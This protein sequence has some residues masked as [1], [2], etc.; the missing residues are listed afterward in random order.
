ML[1][2]S[3]NWWLL[4]ICLSWLCTSSLKDRT[5]Q[6]LAKLTYVSIT[7][8]H[9]IWRI[10][11]FLLQSRFSQNALISSML[12]AA[13]DILFPVQLAWNQ[14]CLRA[15]PLKPWPRTRVRIWVDLSTCWV[16]LSIPPGYHVKISLFVGQGQSYMSYMIKCLVTWPFGMLDS[17]HTVYAIYR[18]DGSALV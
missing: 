10:Q 18:S 15:S 4:Q 16:D 11:L 14:H 3:W 8:L 6:N 9:W 2:C 7:S 17:R 1:E 13:S 5:Q 12:N